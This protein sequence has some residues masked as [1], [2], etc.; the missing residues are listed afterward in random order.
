MSHALSAQDRAGTRAGLVGT[1]VVH[2]GIVVAALTLSRE[3][4]G[5]VPTT[6]QVQLVAAPAPSQARR[7]ATEAVAPPPPPTAPTQ[8]RTTTRTAPV[9]P[10]AAPRA[11]PRSEPAP[12]VAN[13]VVPLPGETPGTGSNIANVNLMG[14]PF[15]FPEYLEN[16]VEQV[17]RRWPRPASGSPLQAEV[18]FTILRDGTVKDIKFVRSS[19]NYTFDLEAMGA[20]ESAARVRAFGA[21]P[22]GF[23]GDALPISFYFAPR[24]GR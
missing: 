14:R 12:A 16:L 9:T 23:E 17:Y 3:P 6:Y 18:A 8:T 15:P 13:P 11:T 20:I 10:P 21:L 24:S 22:A 2:A 7:V 1:A 4:T 19:R 5:F